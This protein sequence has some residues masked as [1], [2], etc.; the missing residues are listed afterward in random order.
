M[1][2]ENSNQNVTTELVKS[3]L[4]NEVS[5]SEDS[6]KL[7]SALRSR[8]V[9][10]KKVKKPIV[11]YDCNEPGHKRPDCPLRKIK[12]KAQEAASVV[13]LGTSANACEDYWTID[14]G[15]TRHMTSR[16]EWFENLRSPESSTKV[17]IADGTKIDSG[18][19]G[20]IS[21]HSGS[22]TVNK[23]KDAIYVPSLNSDSILH[24]SPYRGLYKL[25]CTVNMPRD[26]AC[27]VHSDS[28]TRY[29]LW[30]K[31]LGHLCRIGMNHLRN[32]HVG[33]EFTEIDKESCVACIEATS[34]DRCQ[35]PL[36]KVTSM[37]Y[38]L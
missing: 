34:V 9:K 28:A 31:R 21:I 26:V 4:L 23:I 12:K 6:T 18:G 32:S 36:Y 8:D 1:A 38:Y 13:A 19:I 25:D 16:L 5:K 35:K 29:Q 2:L 3:K 37:P 17:T 24:G 10:P 22:S 33:V 14:S 30:H 27:D 11:C 20:D 15:A 7:D